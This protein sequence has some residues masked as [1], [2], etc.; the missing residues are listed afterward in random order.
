MSTQLLNLL[1]LSDPMLPIGG[2]AHSSGLETYVQA[3]LVKDPATAREFVMQML[4]KNL[5][6][7]DAAFASL[8]YE[9]AA[10]HDRE[11]LLRLDDECTAL[12]MP[13]EIREASHKLGNRLMKVFQPLLKMEITEVYQAHIK[14]GKAFGHYAITYG[15]FAF[16]LG[17]G[18]KEM[19]TGFFYNACAGFVTNIVK[20]VPLGQQDGQELLFSLLPVLDQLAEDCM[21]PDGDL[22]GLCCPGFDIRSIQHESLYSRLYMS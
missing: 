21:Q 11:E 20:M 6:Y 9:V 17:I 7:G 2:Y 5:K 14:E 18:K 19:L 13:R 12:K 8:A 4:S 22:V 3:G 1:Q 16:G 15:L 10:K